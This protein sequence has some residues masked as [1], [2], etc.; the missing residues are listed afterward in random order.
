MKTNEEYKSEILKLINENRTWCPLLWCPLEEFKIRNEDYKK[1]FIYIVNQILND[2]N[3]VSIVWTEY[4]LE[5]VVDGKFK[6]ELI[7]SEHRFDCTNFGG[8]QE[9][10]SYWRDVPNDKEIGF[11]HTVW[12]E[13]DSMTPKSSTLSSPR[14]LS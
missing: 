7:I 8:L 10:L 14:M 3:T 4:D 2:D 9:L 13:K 6:E 12:F 11:M 1:D 5:K